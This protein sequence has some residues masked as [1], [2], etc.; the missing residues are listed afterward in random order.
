MGDARELDQFGD[1]AKLG[2]SR[3]DRRRPLG[4]PVVKD[5]A[6]ADIIIGLLF[7]RSDKVLCRLA[8][9]DDHGAPLHPAIAR[10]APDQP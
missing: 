5:A 3:N 2:I 9:A 6:N 8:A 7:D 1:I 4:V 10:P